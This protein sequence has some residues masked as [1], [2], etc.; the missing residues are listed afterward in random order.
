MRPKVSVSIGRTI[1]DGNY[2]SYRL[3]IGSETSLKENENR[4]AGIL[5][6]LRELEPELGDGLALIIKNL[7]A[8]E[9]RRKGR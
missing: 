3:E 2:G 5:R 7:S 8:Y 6:L 9:E 4:K 1:T